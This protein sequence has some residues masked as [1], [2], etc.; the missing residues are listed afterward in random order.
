MIDRRSVLAAGLTSA[1]GLAV[2]AAARAGDAAPAAAPFKLKYAP[3]FGTFKH[4][5]LIHI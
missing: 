4:L 1:A 5:S 2:G 3:H